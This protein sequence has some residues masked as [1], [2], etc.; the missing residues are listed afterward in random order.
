MSQ[1]SISEATVRKF[2]RE[3][4]NLRL[5]RQSASIADEYSGKLTPQQSELAQLLEQDPDSEATYYLILRAVDR[6]YTEFSA[7]PGALADQVRVK[8]KSVTI[9]LKLQDMVEFSILKSL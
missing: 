8:G 7:L 9:I 6:F 4:S 2:C 1:G 5:I 3:S